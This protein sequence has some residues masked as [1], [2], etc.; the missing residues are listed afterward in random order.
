MKRAAAATPLHEVGTLPRYE[1][2]VRY[3]GPDDTEME[4]WQVPAPATPHLKTPLRIAGLRGR[5]LA[6]VEHR[7][8]TRCCFQP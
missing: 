3:H 6:L 2:R 4:I 8:L 5:N 1:L 7:V